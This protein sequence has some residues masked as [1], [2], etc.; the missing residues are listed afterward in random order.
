MT[1]DTKDNLSMLKDEE[2]LLRAKK[3]YEG[4]MVKS[5]YSGFRY[6]VLKIENVTAHAAT[7]IFVITLLSKNRVEKYTFFKSEIEHHLKLV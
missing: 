3:K 7:G 1:I 5:F 4:K 2:F 6:F